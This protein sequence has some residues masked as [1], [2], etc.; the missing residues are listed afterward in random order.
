MAATEPPADGFRADPLEDILRRCAAAAPAP[1]YPRQFAKSAGVS[2]AEVAADVEFLW[3]EGLLRPRARPGDRVPG[4]TLTEAGARVLSDPAALAALREGP[5]TARAR[6]AAARRALRVGG[7]PVVSRSLLAIN[8]VVFGVGVFIATGLGAAQ[9][10][11]M[12]YGTPAE[13][14]AVIEVLHRTGSVSAEDIAAGRWWRLLTAAFVHGG[15]LHLIMNM[16]M[17]GFGFGIAE[18][19]WG[20]LRYFLIYM[21]AA[22]GGNC[23]AMAWG[24]TAAVVGASGALCGIFGATI[25]WVLFNGQHLPRGA[26]GQM[27]MGLIV[28]AVMLVF[29]SLFPQV[30]G[31]CHLG[32]AL[33][34]AAAAVLLHFQR[35]GNTALRWAAVVG[36]LLLPWLGVKVIEHQRASDPRW[37]GVERK[38]FEHLYDNR[39]AETVGECER[40]YLRRVEPLVAEPPGKR[41]AGHIE[42]VLSELTERRSAL[43]TLVEDLQH[44]GPYLDPKA[45]QGRQDALERAEQLAAKLDK[46]AAALKQNT[47]TPEQNDAEER[48]FTRQFL[49]RIPAVTG[50]A[51]KLDRDD[52]RR[53][54]AT[55]PGQRNAAA[56]EKALQK[57][58]RATRELAD[59]A[60]ALR[61][62]GPYGNSDVEPARQA[63]ERYVAARAALLASEARCLRVSEKWTAEDEAALRKQD[64]EV[65]TRRAEWEKL[66]EPR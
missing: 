24:P 61:E 30:S 65:A 4:V 56:V 18:A 37:H 14:V 50:R 43:S 29:I 6:D 19:M 27:R 5:H 44:T 34:G 47:N 59:L 15:L 16:S 25:V 10:F 12:G 22:F 49:T 35:W 17:L 7:A 20:R 39:L 52:L 41:D 42:H 54:L 48:A 64:D 46:S 13:N 23:V 9:A 55:P 11:L 28:S 36:I 2:L 38:A 40:F 3:M 8:L 26:A 33:F 45:E 31:L 66:V 53:L 57:A 32:G 58:E 1:W 51:I 63:A 62:A 21:L 60:T